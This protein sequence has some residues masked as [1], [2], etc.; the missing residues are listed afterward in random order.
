MFRVPSVCS[1]AQPND[2]RN[3]WDNL[4]QGYAIGDTYLF[5]PSGERFPVTVNRLALHRVGPH[6]FGP[7]D[8]GVKQFSER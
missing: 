1:V 6:F 7:Q 4:A 5:G 8:V 2:N 3:G